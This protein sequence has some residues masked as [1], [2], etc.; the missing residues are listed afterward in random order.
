MIQPNQINFQG[1]IPTLGSLNDSMTLK[2]RL[3][4]LLLKSQV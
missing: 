3:P 2:D 4:K 1:V